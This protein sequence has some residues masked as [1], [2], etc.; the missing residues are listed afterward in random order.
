MTDGADRVIIENAQKADLDA[1][2]FI[3]VF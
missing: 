3:L 2:D 1:Q